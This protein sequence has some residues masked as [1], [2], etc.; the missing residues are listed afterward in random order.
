V[1]VTTKIGGIETY[2]WEVSKVLKELEHDVEIVCGDGKDIKYIDLR[3]KQFPFTSRDKILDLGNRFR[4]WMER[5]SFFINSRSYL[6]CNKYDVFLIHKPFDFFVCYFMK[7]YNK[8]TKTIFISGGEDFYGF[9]RFFSKYI[10]YMFAVSKDN[11]S[12]IKN[13]YKREVIVIPNGVDTNKFKVDIDAR[14]GLRSKYNLVDE[15]VLISVGRIVGWKGFQL[16]IEAL[17]ELKDFKYILIGEGEYL[18]KLKEL[19]K[20]FK[21]EDRVIFIGGIDNKELSKYLN[22][23][24]VFIQPSIG[25]EA[26]GITI[27]EAMSCGLPV[28]ASKNGGIVDIVEDD[29]VGYLFEIKNVKDLIQKV[30]KCY[31][32]R[33]VLGKL[34]IKHVNNN[35]TW[36]SSVNKLLTN[37][38]E[39]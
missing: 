26:F 6:K 1:T 35:F 17:K 32:N 2:Y 27:I 22:I 33:E 13:R 30:N 14:N 21:V 11:A 4:K 25:H 5:V 9:D 39:K 19:A 24:D 18:V 34:A 15:K 16:V 36:K 37:I 7:K 20:K 8:N 29:K 28:V 38:G 31:E 12:K 3:I 23:A 10:D